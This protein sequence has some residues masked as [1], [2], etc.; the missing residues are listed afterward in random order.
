M[1]LVL[2][3]NIETSSDL[4]SSSTSPSTY[5]GI[6]V[7]VFVALAVISTIIA[8]VRRYNSARPLNVV[9]RDPNYRPPVVASGSTSRPGFVPIPPEATRPM[10][11]STTS[12]APVT[13]QPGSL[14]ASTPTVAA[15]PANPTAHEDVCPT[16]RRIRA[17]QAQQQDLL[18]Q[19]NNSLLIQ[20][21]DTAVCAHADDGSAAPASQ[22][23]EAVHGHEHHSHA[24]AP[25]TVPG[26]GPEPA[27]VGHLPA[28]PHTHDPV[29]MP[30]AIPYQATGSTL[31][32]P[33][34]Y[35]VTAT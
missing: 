28:Y 4:S 16:C 33:P 18:L 31:P 29:D 19:G 7:G 20:P 15:A 14:A 23:G 8:Y 11:H 1:P 21:A 3:Q 22:P 30:V 12:P 6:F 27:T 13:T 32:P 10:S 24:H 2:R 35:T 17:V 25:G 9:P 5:I 26:P 34:P